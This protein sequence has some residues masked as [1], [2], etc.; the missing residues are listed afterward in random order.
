[1]EN[2]SDKKHK[3]TKCIWMLGGIINYKLC[4]R[5]F[6]CEKCEFDIVMRGS[7]PKNTYDIEPVNKISHTGCPKENNHTSLL[8]NSYLYTLFSDCKIH[9]DR[10]YHPSHFWFKVESED[11]VLVGIDKLFIKILEPIDKIILPGEGETYCKGQLASLIV[12]KGKTLPLH[13]PLIGKVV[14]ITKLFL[15]NG[16]QKLIEDDNYFFKIEQAGISHEVKHLCSDISGL[17]RFTENINIVRK[18]LGQ[19]FE[20][21]RPAEIGTTLPDGGN[22]QIGLEKVI[23]EQEFQN[24]VKRIFHLNN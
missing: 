11:K 21:S 1:M 18:F 2:F 12:R 17:F 3:D 4:D 13:L 19:A 20:S 9:L 10:Y 24:L 6:K 15:Q 22:F 16:F 14:E 8:I 7:F 5:N 23:G